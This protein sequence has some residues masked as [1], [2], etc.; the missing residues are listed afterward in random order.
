MDKAGGILVNLHPTPHK[1]RIT[2]PREEMDIP[3]IPDM[4]GDNPHIHSTLGGK[5]KRGE[6]LVVHDQVGRADIEVP[7]GA[8]DDVE[9]NHLTDQIPVERESA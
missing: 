3:L 6:G 5:Q 9:V 4:R 2:G 1:L 8:V 7:L